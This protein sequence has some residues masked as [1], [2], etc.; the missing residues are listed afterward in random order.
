MRTL[1]WINV[2]L[3]AMMEAGIVVALAVWGWNRGGETGA[4]VLLG[5]GAPVLLFGIWAMIDF[6]AAGGAAEALRLVEELVISGVA[7]LA[8]YVVGAVGFAF[9]LGTISLVHH[10]L[11]YVCGDRLL[12]PRA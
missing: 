11:V 2:G 1:R 10:A 8:F 7:A 3:R 9:A 6:R 5:V 4:R 12:A